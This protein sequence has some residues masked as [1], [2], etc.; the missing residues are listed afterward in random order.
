MKQM[1]IFQTE[2]FEKKI[3]GG[4]GGEVRAYGNTV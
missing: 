4:L 3:S 1:V 2:I